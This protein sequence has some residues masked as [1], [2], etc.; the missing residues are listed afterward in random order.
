MHISVKADDGDETVVRA[1]LVSGELALVTIET[2][3]VQINAK[4]QPEAVT[5]TA[6]KARELAKA[7]TSVADAIDF[8]RTNEFALP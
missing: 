4:I 3:S 7:L 5:L 8:V 1:N 2:G 6:D